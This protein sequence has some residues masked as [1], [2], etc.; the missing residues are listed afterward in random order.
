M[1]F[2]GKELIALEALEKIS[3]GFRNKVKDERTNQYKTAK[4][5]YDIKISYD[6]KKYLKE[7][8]D[9]DLEKLTYSLQD[10]EDKKLI[11]RKGK[12]DKRLAVFKFQSEEFEYRIFKFQVR[13]RTPKELKKIQNGNK[14]LSDEFLKLNYFYAKPLRLNKNL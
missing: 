2:I 14:Y 12:R 10:I 8:L 6:E 11:F 1:D 4:R 5:F 13:E 7:I 3:N 9:F